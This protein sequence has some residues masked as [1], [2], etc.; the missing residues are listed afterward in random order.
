MNL[1]RCRLDEPLSAGRDGVGR[2]SR[3]AQPILTRLLQPFAKAGMVGK[4][5]TSGVGHDCAAAWL[6][7]G[8]EPFVG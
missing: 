8:R 5:G 7:F 2:A 6:G 1:G 4:G 3:A